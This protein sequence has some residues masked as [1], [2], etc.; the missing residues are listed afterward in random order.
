MNLVQIIYFF[1]DHVTPKIK[2]KVDGRYRLEFLT[3]INIPPHL[4]YFVSL[5]Y[6]F[7]LNTLTLLPKMLWCFAT[8][9]VYMTVALIVV[10][11][12]QLEKHRLTG[13]LELVVTAIMK[14]LSQLNYIC[15]PLYLA[16]GMML[17]HWNS[18]KSNGNQWGSYI[19]LRLWGPVYLF[20]FFLFFLQHIIVLES[21]VRKVL[22]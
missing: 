1:I 20:S 16:I 17:L 9:G 3:D 2:Q 6:T 10:L 15:C 19:M 22:Q 21:I 13:H 5:L 12:H 7:L 14:E 4:Y 8:G 18:T 11:I